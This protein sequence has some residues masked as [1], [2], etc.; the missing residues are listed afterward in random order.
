MKA[1]DGS[2]GLVFD[3]IMDDGAVGVVLVTR[4]G[5]SVAFFVLLEIAGPIG[6]QL[7]VENDPD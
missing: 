4:V 3:G 2:A 7:S 5:S 1:W 6:R